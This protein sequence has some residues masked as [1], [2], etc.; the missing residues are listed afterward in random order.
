MLEKARASTWAPLTR[1]TDKVDRA[2]K[3]LFAALMCRT[4]AAPAAL[5]AGNDFPAAPPAWMAG[6]KVRIPMYEFHRVHNGNARLGNQLLHTS[7]VR[8]SDS[9]VIPA[10]Y[11]GLTASLTPIK[12]LGIE[13]A[14][15][16]R[17]KNRT[18]P[19][20]PT[21]NLY[22]VDGPSFWYGGAVYGMRFGKSDLKVQGCL[23]RFTDIAGR[24]TGGHAGKVK[25]LYW[26]GGNRAGGY[27]ASYARYSQAQFNHPSEAGLE[28]TCFFRTG[29]FKRF[30]HPRSPGCLQL[31]RA[32]G[33]VRIQP[34]AVPV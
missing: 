1:G 2:I 20:F 16:G 5:A 10:A 30:F 33:H 31:F 26:F 19:D 13:A 18:S 22:G 29:A 12:N 24:T 32:A 17:W 3:R 15:I 14:Y 6:F 28:A 8:G 27:I 4:L 23:S 25:G 34:S 11:R 21:T 7:W 9:R